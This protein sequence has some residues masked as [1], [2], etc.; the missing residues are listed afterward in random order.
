VL[1]DWHEER[2]ECL[3]WDGDKLIREAIVRENRP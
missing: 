3:A 1:A 2:G